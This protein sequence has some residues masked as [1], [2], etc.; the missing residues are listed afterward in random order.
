MQFKQVP[1]NWLQSDDDLELTIA[2]VYR[3]LD[4]ACPHD[5]SPAYALQILHQGTSSPF[6][7]LLDWIGMILQM[8]GREVGGHI[9]W[10]TQE[11]RWAIDG[12]VGI[13]GKTIVRDC[14][15][16]YIN[17][18]DIDR[19]PRD[20]MPY[21]EDEALLAA[22]PDG[23]EAIHRSLMPLPGEIARRVW[24]ETIAGKEEVRV[25]DIWRDRKQPHEFNWCLRRL[26]SEGFL[27]YSA[28]PLPFWQ[29]A[30]VI[31]PRYVP[32]SASPTTI[33]LARNSALKEVA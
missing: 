19:F 21:A 1:E 24:T 2:A 13:S 7:P 31:A 4:A 14:V 3:A 12:V 8:S 11:C 29:V 18:L 16:W 17:Q 6:T 32:E 10:E 9:R 5:R 26:G 15:R 30:G 27:A 25:F 22:N 28:E 33:F 20:D 23:I